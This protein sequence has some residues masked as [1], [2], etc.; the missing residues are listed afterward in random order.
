MARLTSE[1]EGPGKLQAAIENNKKWSVQVD[2]TYPSYKKVE[3]SVTYGVN[4]GGA[5]AK[6]KMAYNPSEG[7][8]ALYEVV[9]SHSSGD[10]AYDVQQNATLS[11]TTADGNHMLEATAKND[12]GDLDH[13]KAT[14]LKYTAKG[15]DKS[16]ES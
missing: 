3:P 2:K 15:D 8:R 11:I 1:M 10:V 5:H 6:L 12:Q 13:W 14:S 4:E 16:L 7:A 9:T